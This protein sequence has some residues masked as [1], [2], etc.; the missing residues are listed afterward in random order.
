MSSDIERIR[1]DVSLSDTAAQF[2]LKLQRDGGE[3]VACCPFHGEGTPSFTIF[4][5]KDHVE[6]FH[7]FGCGEAGDVL[8][9]VKGIKGVDL[10]E[11]IAI[12]GGKDTSRPNIAPRKVE[13]R[14]IYEGIKPKYPPAD[15]EIEKDKR[16]HLYNP[17]RAGTERE[18]GS[19]VPSMVFPYRQADGRLYGYVLR[20]DLPDGKETPMVM[21]CVLPNGDACWC[22]YPFQK[23]RPLYGLDKLGD[24]GRQVIVVEGEKCA[25]KLRKATGR[26]VVSWPGGTQGV[27]HADWSPLANR[28]V[29]IWPDADEPG[30]ATANEIA[31]IVHALGAT[32]RVMYIV[33]EG[34]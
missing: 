4:T 30:V 12:L 13:V 16:V 6:R 19:F 27:K 8:D 23:P 5:G 17:K 24:D 29:V 7:C 20:H 1:R 31:G 3:F 28:N 9:Y 34:K 21:W 2:G 10:R 14:D 11:A 18:W 15:A 25:D 33:R 22:R 26:T 32:A